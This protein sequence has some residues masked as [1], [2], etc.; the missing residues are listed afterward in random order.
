MSL[1]GEAGEAG[2]GRGGRGSRGGR[3]TSEA[4]KGR[5]GRSSGDSGVE[6]HGNLDTLFGRR[7]V[8]EREKPRV[9]GVGEFSSYGIFG[10]VEEDE[11]SGWQR[12]E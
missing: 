6:G 10:E 12:V 2:G 11:L 3:R 7:S 8:L 1:R 9:E 5:G 4:Q